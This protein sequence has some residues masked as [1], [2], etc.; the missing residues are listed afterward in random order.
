MYSL[1]KILK[2]ILKI[3]FFFFKWWLHA[4]MVP[5]LYYFL[6][7]GCCMDSNINKFKTC[8]ASKIAIDPANIR[9]RK[10]IHANYVL[11]ITS[12][13]INNGL[14]SLEHYKTQWSNKISQWY[15]ASLFSWSIGNDRVRFSVHGDD[16]YRGLGPTHCWGQ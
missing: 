1:L 14:I 6:I 3:M 12:Y 9:Y 11:I 7:M 15:S 5:F 8:I 13:Y 4:P 2:K 10:I 16:F